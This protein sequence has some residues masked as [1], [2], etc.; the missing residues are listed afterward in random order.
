MVAGQSVITHVLP[1]L[2]SIGFSGRSAGI[3]A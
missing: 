2:A 1:Y 3:I